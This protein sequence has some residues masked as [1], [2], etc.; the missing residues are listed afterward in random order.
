MIRFK[1]DDTFKNFDW[2][3]YAERCEKNNNNY[4]RFIWNWK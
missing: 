4:D 2:E 1:T 3:V